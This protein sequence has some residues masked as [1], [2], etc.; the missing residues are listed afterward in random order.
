MPRT[1]LFRAFRRAVALS[2]SPQQGVTRKD[3]LKHSGAALGAAAFGLPKLLAAA[4]LSSEEPVAILGAGV[5]GLTAAYR[6]QQAG[7]PWVLYEASDRFGGRMFTKRAFNADGMFC[8]LGGELVDTQH[9]SIRRLIRELGL[10]TQ[11]LAQ[12]KTGVSRNLY[13]FGGRVYTDDDLREHVGPLVDAVVRDLAA[14]FGSA[15]RRMITYKDAPPGAERLDRMTLRAYLDSLSG[16]E[17]WV[18]GAIESAYLTEYGLDVERQS[19]LNL[20][21]LVSTAVGAGDFELFGDSDEALRVVGGSQRVTDALAKRLSLESSGTHRYKPSHELVSISDAGAKLKLAFKTPGGTVEKSYGRALCA[22]PFSVLRGVDGVFALDMSARKKE[23]IR[24]MSYGTNSKLMLGFSDRYWRTGESGAPKSNGGLFSDLPGQSYWE[25]SRAQKGRRGIIT[26]YTGV[27]AGLAREIKHVDE[28]LADME[29]VFP[30]V[31]K[32]FDGSTALFNWGRYRHNLGSYI[33]P[34]PGDYT[35][36]YGAAGDP[37]CG[38]RLFFAG[39]HATV[40]NC[41]YM[42]G[43]VAA[44]EAAVKSLLAGSRLGQARAAHGGVDRPQRILR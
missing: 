4:A 14:L 32:R 6:L 9:R 25:T 12:T 39:E 41:G 33:C 40:D 20:H 43:G 11:T 18:R 26:N 19:A 29:T 38:G 15:P 34:A 28:C 10:E 31:K 44:A 17:K 35:S 8:E 21:M 36:W 23:A 13:W 24:K 22:I 42:N 27:A 7:V 1:D 5:S 2:R 16:V 30:S 3:F 37:E